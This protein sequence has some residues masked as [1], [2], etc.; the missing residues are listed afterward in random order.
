MNLRHLISIYY[1]RVGGINT[2][3]IWHGVVCVFLFSHLYCA[4]EM[5]REA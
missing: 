5:L 3:G 4:L 1:N 2:I